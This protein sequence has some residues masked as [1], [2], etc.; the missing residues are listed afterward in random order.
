MVPSLKAMCLLDYALSVG[1]Q[2]EAV[3]MLFKAFYVDGQRID[4]LEVLREVAC[5][6]GLDQEQATR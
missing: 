3:N 2:N 6:S 5:H 1:K 4:S